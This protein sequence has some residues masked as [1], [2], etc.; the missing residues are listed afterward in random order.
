MERFL[1]FARNDERVKAE[2]VNN[3]HEVKPSVD[4]GYP[5]ESH[6]KIPAFNSIDEEAEYWDSHDITDDLD[7]SQPAKTVMRRDHSERPADDC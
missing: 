5:T 1:D 7:E 3:V 6:G 4:L 2:E